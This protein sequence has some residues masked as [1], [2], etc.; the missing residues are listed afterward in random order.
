ML[1]PYLTYF[2]LWL[3][4]KEAN[5][6]Y[7]EKL[8]SNTAASKVLF[9]LGW[10]VDE[11]SRLNDTVRGMTADLQLMIETVRDENCDMLATNIVE[12]VARLS[13]SATSF[14]KGK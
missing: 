9:S 2:H 3:G 6:N 4:L 11:L 10:K 8:A 1:L 12:R 5:S 14:L 13:Q 7:S